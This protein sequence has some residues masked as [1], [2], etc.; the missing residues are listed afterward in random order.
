[1]YG[2]ANGNEEEIEQNEDD[3]LLGGGEPQQK[4]QKQEPPEGG[5]E[6]KPDLG[7]ALK[8]FSQVLRETKTQKTES[9]PAR[10][11]TKEEIAEFWAVF[12]PEKA[13]PKFFNQFFRLPDDATP[14]EIA[15]VRQQF[16]LLQD[17][18]MKQAV[19]AAQVM[20]QKEREEIMSEFGPIKEYI[21]SQRATATT[22]RFHKA[23]PALS[24]SK[25]SR[26]L[27]AVH[28]ELS[29]SGTEFKTEK[30][31]FKALAEGAAEAIAPF[32]P[33]FSLTSTKT[34]TPV[35]TPRLPR[36]AGGS[37]GGAG[38]RGGDGASD[39]KSAMDMLLED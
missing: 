27:K 38:N 9:A 23:Y 11:P 16:G 31:F 19:R 1:M 33:G 15:T 28:H 10:E 7:A 3:A 13:N 20:V 12:N 30:D 36:T 17:G 14:E 29:S 18:F 37:T 6:E 24:D 39:S 8:E 21:Q 34:K 2:T 35:T 5:E 25:Y 32:E 4:Q 26:I 22:D